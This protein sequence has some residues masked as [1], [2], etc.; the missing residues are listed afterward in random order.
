MVGGRRIRA[1]LADASV[2]ALESIAGVARAERHGESVSLVCSNSDAAIRGLLAR[3]PET[4]D[5]EIVGAGLEDAF[6][7]LTA[8][9][10]E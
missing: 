7:E 10:I 2:S 8:G 1:T 5:I 6:V 4:S 3:F 9:G